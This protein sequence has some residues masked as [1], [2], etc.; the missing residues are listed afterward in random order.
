MEP[1]GERC[2]VPVI[3]PKDLKQAV[4]ANQAGPDDVAEVD[5]GT[6]HQYVFSGRKVDGSKTNPP[7]VA[8]SDS[9]PKDETP[10]SETVP[11]KAET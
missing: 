11:T 1:S 7:G 5:R 2:Q 9:A 4:A 3:H 8:T 6:E 10:K